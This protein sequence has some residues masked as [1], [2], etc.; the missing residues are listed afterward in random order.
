MADAFHSIVRANY[1]R[2]LFAAKADVHDYGY[3]INPSLLKPMI[4]QIIGPRDPALLAYLAYLLD[5]EEYLADGKIVR[6]SMGG[7]PG[8]PM[9]SFF[10][11]VYLMDLDRALTQQSILCVRYADDIAA[12]T[13]SR[14]EAREALATTRAVTGGLGL[15]L[16]EK[17]TQVIA[18]G[19]DIEL[20]GIAVRDG[21]L[22]VSDHTLAKVRTKL[23][24]Y[25]N[26]RPPDLRLAWLVAWR[27][28]QA[29]QTREAWSTAQSEVCRSYGCSSWLPS[30][31]TPSWY[32]HKA[33]ERAR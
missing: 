12:F 20:L 8:I 27:S 25:A 22:D 7:L 17:K 33:T 26:K 4:E 15:A 5:R 6:G 11:N 24:H 30:T 13:H 2:N 23:T 28:L 9:G 19:E 3:S 31:W 10:N 21:H 18:P 16:N 32:H 14:E 1:A 29:D